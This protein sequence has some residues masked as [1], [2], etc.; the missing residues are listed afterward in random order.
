MPRLGRPP[1]LDEELIDK[2]V[3]LTTRGI[4]IAQMARK[5][6]VSEDALR[7]WLDRGKADQSNG[8]DSLYSQ[9]FGKL[10]K[11][12]A[13]KIDEYIE[14]MEALKNYQSLAWLLGKIDPEHLSEHSEPYQKLKEL[15][16][17]IHANNL[18]KETK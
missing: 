10:N 17:Q 5:A 12:K 16:E 1:Q 11:K 3:N 18:G 7:I 15:V 9:L 4:Y 13:E 8:I 6:E 14:S 2:L